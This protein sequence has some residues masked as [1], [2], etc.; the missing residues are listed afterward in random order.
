MLY[1]HLS[2]ELSVAQFKLLQSEVRLKMFSALQVDINDISNY[3]NIDR[4]IDNKNSARIK[5]IS[6]IKTMIY[7][8]NIYKDGIYEDDD[9][10]EEDKLVIESEDRCRGVTSNAYEDVCTLDEIMQEIFKLKGSA[11][12]RGK[13]ESFLGH[14]LSSCMGVLYFNN[15]TAENSMNVD[16][17]T[18]NSRHENLFCDPLTSYIMSIASYIRSPR[19]SSSLWDLFSHVLSE[20]LTTMNVSSYYQPSSCPSHDAPIRSCV[21]E[22]DGN[23][24]VKMNFM[25]DISSLADQ[26]RDRREI[27]INMAIELQLLRE[28]LTRYDVTNGN[29]VSNDYSSCWYFL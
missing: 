21:L 29:L 14:S 27:M 16:R 15:G 7:S 3:G 25:D 4:T 28:K 13:E 26:S 19:N 22:K 11:A 2:R 18:D 20:I 10:V 8:D 24:H 5:N 9:L 6:S 17:S 12:F 23:P 1:N